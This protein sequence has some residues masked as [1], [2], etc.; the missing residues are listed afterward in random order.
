[1]WKGRKTLMKTFL[2]A[3]VQGVDGMRCNNINRNYC[4]KLCVLI[5]LQI[6]FPQYSPK[7]VKAAGFGKKNIQLKHFYKLT[8]TLRKDEPYPNRLFIE[9]I[10]IKK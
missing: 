1:M 7:T 3:L 4:H 5:L 9:I 6:P 10:I 2:P 8:A